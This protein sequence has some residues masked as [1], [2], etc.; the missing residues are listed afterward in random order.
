MRPPCLLMKPNL[1]IKCQAVK[2]VRKWK[3]KDFQ[4]SEPWRQVDWIGGADGWMKV[5]L[6]AML[7]CGFHN[8]CLILSLTCAD[9]RIDAGGMTVESFL[10]FGGCFLL[11]LRR[12]KKQMGC[13]SK[14]RSGVC[15]TYGAL[16]KKCFGVLCI[17]SLVACVWNLCPV[18]KIWRQVV[19]QAGAR[20]F[21]WSLVIVR[22]IKPD[23]ISS[24]LAP[25]RCQSAVWG[26]II[27]G[28]AGH[29][30]GRR[31]SGLRLVQMLARDH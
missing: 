27:G 9:C 14:F 4:I 12:H 25:A 15:K 13:K 26:Q 1:L 19:D 29:H 21:R 31:P 22:W 20:W 11:A 24:I 8:T 2:V 28:W 5:H 7:V 17:K 10:F 23:L 30:C 18:P 16:F 6:S 3:T